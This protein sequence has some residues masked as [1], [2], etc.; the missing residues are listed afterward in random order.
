MGGGKCPSLAKKGPQALRRK[1]I[2]DRFGATSKLVPF[3]I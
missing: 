1:S 2:F 3:P